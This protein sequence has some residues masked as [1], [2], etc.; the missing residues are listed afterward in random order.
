MS[1]RRQSR[2][3]LLDRRLH[4]SLRSRVTTLL[5][6]QARANHCG[7]SAKAAGCR[8]AFCHH[9]RMRLSSQPTIPLAFADLRSTNTRFSSANFT[10]ACRAMKTFS[11]HCVPK[12]PSGP[13]RLSLPIV[14][15][16]NRR[17]T[18]RAWHLPPTIQPLQTHR[19][20]DSRTRR[21]ARR[22]RAEGAEP[23]GFSR[24]GRGQRC[25]LR[26]PLR[27]VGTRLTPHT[28]LRSRFYAIDRSACAGEDCIELS[29]LDCPRSTKP[30]PNFSD[31]AF[32]K[33]AGSAFNADL[34]E[35]R[36]SPKRRHRNKPRH[37]KPASCDASGKT[38]IEESFT[39]LKR[40]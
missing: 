5:R 20:A 15:R 10:S 36:L 22:E 23:R 40:E 31:V 38:H 13:S 7:F 11:L 37:L 28:E 3:G 29:C 26:C 6:S 17:R 16:V 34:L 1:D 2:S 9:A 39:G 8:N 14:V 30:E 12:L 24:D 4:E 18:P 32:T 25:T 33:N 27:R 35:E 21:L 19:F